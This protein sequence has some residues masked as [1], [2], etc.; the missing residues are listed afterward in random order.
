MKEIKIMKVTF[1]KRGDGSYVPRLFLSMKDLKR[2]GISP[3]ER[4]IEYVFDEERQEI[5][6]RKKK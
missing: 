3:D 4:D 1:G 6:I 5:V 2:L